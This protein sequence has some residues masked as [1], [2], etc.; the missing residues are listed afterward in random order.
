MKVM[1]WLAIHWN[2]DN[3]ACPLAFLE[4]YRYH[5]CTDLSGTIS[6][7]SSLLQVFRWNNVDATNSHLFRSNTSKMFSEKKCLYGQFTGGS[8]K[9]MCINNVK[10][11]PRSNVKE[12]SVSHEAVSMQYFACSGSLCYLFHLLHGQ[13]AFRPFF[14]CTLFYLKLSS[15]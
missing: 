12:S 3:I 15:H 4:Q 6:V 13:I 14:L 8:L 1:Q 11:F 7:F 2:S 10:I 5:L 9:R